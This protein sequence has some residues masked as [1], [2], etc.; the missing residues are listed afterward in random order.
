M[1]LHVVDTASDFVAETTKR[2]TR[3]HAWIGDE[4]AVLFY[5]PED[6]AK[7]PGPSRNSTI[8]TSTSLGS[9]WIW[10]RQRISRTRKAWRLIVRRHSHAAY[11]LIAKLN[12]VRS[13]ARPS[14]WSFVRIDETC[15]GRSGGLLQSTLPLFQGTRFWAMGVSF[16][17]SFSSVA[18]D[19]NHLPRVGLS[20]VP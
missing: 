3:F 18:E 1:A 8:A 7:W 17:W 2:K 9:P 5:H 15:L 12:I 6:L 14:I 19:E 20:I 16:D 13:R 11:S 4:W 10:S